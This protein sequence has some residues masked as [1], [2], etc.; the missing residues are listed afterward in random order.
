LSEQARE[1]S[2]GVMF[3]FGKPRA[4]AEVPRE[5]LQC[6]FCQK[7]QDQISK[8]IAGPAV[9]IC[10]ECVQICV[11][12]IA[13]DAAGRGE[14]GETA[15]ARARGAAERMNRDHAAQPRVDSELPSWH[16]RCPLCEMVVPTDDAIPIIGLGVLCRPC[17]LAIRETAP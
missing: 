1:Y 8:L 4:R 6:S 17:V 15:E 10:D 9:F 11:D 7:S 12:I 13:N 3:G 16:V 14:T 5:R 2:E